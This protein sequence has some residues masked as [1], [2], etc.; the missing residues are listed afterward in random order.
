MTKILAAVL[1]ATVLLPTGALAAERSCTDEGRD[2]WM[3]ADAI[4]AKA[5]AA[6]YKNI[7]QVKV[8]GSCYEIYGFDAKGERAEIN[9]NPVTGAIV[10]GDED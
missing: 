5:E 1:A 4:K 6:G 3:S 9:V 7:R 2:K 10:G 8:E